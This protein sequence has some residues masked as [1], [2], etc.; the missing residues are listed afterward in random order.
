MYH[1]K[2]CLF[3]Q[4]DN[5]TYSYD[6]D[7]VKH[8]RQGFG[9]FIWSSGDTYTGNWNEKGNFH[10]KEGNH[11][12]WVDKREYKGGYVN[13]MKHGHGVFTWPKGQKYEGPWEDGKQH[14][15]GMY[16]NL[17][18]VVKEVEYVKGKKQ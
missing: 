7:W 8:D 12:V 6:G 3:T 2:G 9:T 11:F 17:K 13:G 4:N 5:E 10:G 1:G 16:T 18:G 15:T 14:G